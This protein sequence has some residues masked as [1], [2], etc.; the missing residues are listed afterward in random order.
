VIR[1][2]HR[3]LRFPLFALLALAACASAPPRVRTGDGPFASGASG[4]FSASL[5]LVADAA[6]FAAAVRAPGD[7][8]EL[9][10]AHSAAR[11]EQISAFVA[12][13]GCG[14]AATGL[15]D[16]RVDFEVRD[17]AG[18]VIARESDVAL[19]RDPPEPSPG[20][21]LFGEAAA[22]LALAPDARTGTW[23][24]SAVVRDVALGESVALRTVLDVR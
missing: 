23:Q 6:G 4:E 14:A 5:F 24:I 8:V 2:D 22:T 16:V 19:W 21:V 11:G 13:K 9:Q 10:V 17:P 3:S 12:V 15:C 18:T 7:P 1:V 20:D